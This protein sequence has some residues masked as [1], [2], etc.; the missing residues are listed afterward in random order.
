MLYQLLS[1]QNL[2][3]NKIRVLDV[4]FFSIIVKVSSIYVHFYTVHGCRLEIE[5]FT[6][7]PNSNNNLLSSTRDIM[8]V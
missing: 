6:K 2:T 8:Q 5:N 1:D 3:I 4:S 7:I